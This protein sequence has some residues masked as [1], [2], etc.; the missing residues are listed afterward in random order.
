M[1][2][3]VE[4]GMNFSMSRSAAKAT[5][6]GMELSARK[7][8]FKEAFI[9]YLNWGGKY[10]VQALEVEPI[11]NKSIRKMNEWALK[12]Q[13]CD[14]SASLI[15]RII[16]AVWGIFTW[17]VSFF[18]MPS[19]DNQMQAFQTYYVQ[20]LQS[21]RPGAQAVQQ[22]RAAKQAFKRA[23]AQA[24]I[25]ERMALF[26]AKVH[27]VETLKHASTMTAKAIYWANK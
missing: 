11:E 15:S 22:A 17:V 24:T 18:Y 4:L 3:L 1:A 2:N 7:R 20:I 9:S 21:E 16:N 27:A 12:K 10:E 6:E 19:F 8:A 5:V 25:E 14:T 23:F 13:K 26:D